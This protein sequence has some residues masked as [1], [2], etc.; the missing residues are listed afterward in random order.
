MFTAIEIIRQNLSIPRYSDFAK[1][2]TEPDIFIVLKKSCQLPN[3][4]K[5][6]IL[7][8]IN[9]AENSLDISKVG[10]FLVECQNREENKKM[11]SIVRDKLS[12]SYV[13]KE[14]NGISPRI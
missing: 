6:D 3:K 4:V 7:G 9:P 13:V 12:D 1:N 14:I 11:L 2:K 10:G 8:K 5:A